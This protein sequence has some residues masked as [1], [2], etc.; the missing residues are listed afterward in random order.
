MHHR[1]PDW[2]D[3]FHTVTWEINAQVIACDRLSFS[4]AT[5]TDRD[6]FQMN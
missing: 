2:V 1:K 6:K 4:H 5:H 3:E